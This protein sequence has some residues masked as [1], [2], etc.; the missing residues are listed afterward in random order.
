[1]LFISLFT[2]WT[3]EF[4][5]GISW[6]I[7]EFCIVV[8]DSTIHFQTGKLEFNLICLTTTTTMNW[9]L[10]WICIKLLILF[11]LVVFVFVFVC[12]QCQCQLSSFPLSLCDIIFWHW[13][14]NAVLKFSP[15]QNKKL[16][17]DFWQALLFVW[18]WSAK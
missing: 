18:W 7:F 5:S 11:Q 3:I 8:L 9:T 15:K 14:Y 12:T 4:F 17:N 6:T 1:M 2:G 16:L 10:I 13:K